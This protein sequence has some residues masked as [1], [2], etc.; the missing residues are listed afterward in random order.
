MNLNL[1]TFLL[2][3]VASFFL[4]SCQTDSNTNAANSAEAA[5]DFKDYIE[6]TWQ[7]VQ[8]NVAVNSVDGLDSFRVDNLS[9]KV[10]RSEFGVNP[11]K[12]YFQPDNKFRREHTSITGE[13]MDEG[14]GM[15]NVF[16]DTLV[17]IEPDA[18]Y[19][20]VVKGDGSRVTFRTLLDWD[21]DGEADDQFQALHRK[22]S[23]SSE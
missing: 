17:L 6:G 13:L 5:F 7:T 12:Y 23:V 21:E 14:K 8:I 22:I 10:W 18:T 11:P 20:Y 1:Y 16:G 9:E 4:P 15:W 3:L 2:L 19:Q